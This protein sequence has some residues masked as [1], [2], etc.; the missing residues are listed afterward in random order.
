LPL[1]AAVALVTALG[2]WWLVPR[3]GL[4]GAAVALALSALTQLLGSGLILIYALRANTDD[5]SSLR[6]DGL[7]RCA[8]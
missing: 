7:S 2:C 5:E 3:W 1:F 8:S 6:A 4:R